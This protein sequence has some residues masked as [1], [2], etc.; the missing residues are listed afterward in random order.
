MKR[1]WR[2]RL[3]QVFAADLRSLALLRVALGLIVIC[4]VALRARDLS[5]FYSDS[6]VL[7]RAAYLQRVGEG[8]SW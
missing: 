4:D 2:D 5:A 6:G 1:A 3:G 8:W 7:S